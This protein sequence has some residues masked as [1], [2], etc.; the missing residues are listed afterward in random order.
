MSFRLLALDL[1][2]TT[3]NSAK[4]LTHRTYNAIMALVAQ[5]W[6]VTLASG[7]RPQSMIDFARQLD[8]HIPI[9]AF[10]G[11][12]IL[13]PQNLHVCRIHSIDKNKAIRCIERWHSEGI[14]V[15]M[16]NINLEGQEYVYLGQSLD[17]YFRR[18]VF[19]RLERQGNALRL[20]TPDQLNFAPLRM[21]V[22]GSESLSLRA[23]ALVED[24]LNTELSGLW[25]MHSMDYDG[26]WFYEIVPSESTK[27][28]ALSYISDLLGIHPD[29]VVAVGDQVNDIDMVQFAGLGVAMGNAVPELKAVADKVIGIHDEDGLAAFLETLI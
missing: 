29:E 7:R 22:G 4:I 9:A 11:G 15:E 21:L 1:D 28:S 19:E 27:G 20:Y 8:I 12:M 23:K 13:D 2:G 16:Q 10:N 25:A 18:D 5:G 24:L 14:G 17:G 26:L 3:L 6:K